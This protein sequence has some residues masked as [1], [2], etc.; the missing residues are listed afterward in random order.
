[1]AGAQNTAPWSYEGRTGPINWGKLDPAYRACRDGHEQSPVDIRGAHLNKALPALE[2]H[3]MGSSMSL[4]NNGR[5]IVAHANPGSYFIDGGVRYDL[6]DLVFHHPSEEAVHGKLSDMDV[7]LVHTSADGKQAVIEVRLTED[8]GD[9][10]ATLAT[11]WAHMPT[12]PGTTQNVTDMVNPAGLLPADRG[13]WT[14][15]GSLSTPPCTEG[16]RWF[17]MEQDLSISRGQLRQFA[18][19]FRVSSRQLQDAHGRRIEANE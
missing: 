6:K 16:V 4:E 17:V 7:E 1:M 14:F 8:R 12:T 18:Q 5:T 15:M 11:L 10:S 3:Y 13:Y 9:P 19:M 2:F